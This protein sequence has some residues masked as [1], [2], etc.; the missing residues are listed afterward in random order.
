MKEIILSSTI[1]NSI[2]LGIEKIEENKNYLNEINYFP[3]PDNDTGENLNHLMQR[4]KKEIRKKESVK[5]ILRIVSDAAIKGS[6]GNSGAIFSQFFQGLEEGCPD[7]TVINTSELIEC[8]RFGSEYAYSALENPVEGTILT[9][10]STFYENLKVYRD[11]Q[12]HVESIFE[13]SYKKLKLTVEE[14]KYTLKSKT[15]IHKVD[16]GALGFMYFVRGFIDGINGKEANE[17]N[18]DYININK[19]VKTNKFDFH[20]VDNFRYCTEVLMRND[21]YIEKSN[22]QNLLKKYGDSIVITENKNYRRTHIHTNEPRQIIEILSDLG[23]IIEVKADDMILQQR[24]SKKSDSDI[25]IVIDSIADLPIDNLP[26]F[27]YMLP[28]NLM[29]EGVSYQDKVSAPK[30]LSKY[31]K[32]TSSQTNISE[33]RYFLEPIS[34]RHKHIIVLTVS[35]KMSGL[36]ERYLEFKQNN[37]DMLLEI[38]DT[39]LNSVAEGQVAYHAINKIKEGYSFNEL[40]NYIENI[41]SRN[42]IFV[43]LKNL[44]GMIKSGRL[45]KKIGW[46]LQKVGFLPLVTI[47]KDGNGSINKKAFT[48]K[49]N[50]A[51]L[52]KEIEDNK[53][54]IE[55]YALVH[56]N[57]LNKAK[58]LEEYLIERL[59]FPPLY[60][61]EASSIIENFSG[62][63]SIAIGYQLK[64][65]YE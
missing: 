8:F 52:L 24:L 2:L 55:S 18:L 29:V 20:I 14:T 47:D 3:V 46:L 11:E 13:E 5:D 37:P 35:S 42:K 4:I 22:L 64:E 27:V 32:V 21:K 16:A 62:D 19:E 41:I 9:A 23:E 15:S 10:F 39:K 60:I 65:N 50:Y 48:Q 43:S 45:N 6:R 63:G 1:Y 56:V 36:Y 54:K 57:N 30:N 44:D 33:I 51:N 59:G 28:L 31:K 12:R 61:S 25:G 7:K 34:K 17:N 53:D 26:D 40:I 38:I 49:S 58:E